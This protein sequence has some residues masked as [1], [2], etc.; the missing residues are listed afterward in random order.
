MSKK[1]L[2][3][4][5]AYFHDSAVALI[6]NGQVVAAA[7]EERFSRKKN[8]ASFP[9]HAIT[10]CLDFAKIDLTALEAVV[11]FEKPIVKFSRVVDS[12]FYSAPS[13]FL[14]Y[15]KTVPSWIKNKL[16]LRKT[17]TQE[18]SKLTLN[19][20]NPLPK[21]LFS[22]HHMSHAAASFYPSPFKSAAI[23][24]LD[25]VGEYS[26]TTAWLGEDTEIT[27]L[28]EIDFPDSLGL[29]YSAF[30]HYAGFKV[31]S[32]EYKL[33][34]LAP[35]GNP[36][37]VNQIMD[38]LI[39]IREDGSFK[40]NMVYFDFV[41]GENMINDRFSK[42]FGESAREPE[43]TVTQHHMDVAAS[44]QVVTEKVMM[45]LLNSLY[46]ETG[47]KKNLCLGGGVALNCVANGKILEQTKFEH[48]WIQPAA[49]DAGSALGG[50]LA[51][52]HQHYKEPRNINAH[53]DLM[54]ASYLGPAYD[55]PSIQK[56]LTEHEAHFEYLE[57]SE[58][59]K[60]V[61]KL[62]AE[63]HVVG[64]FQGRM[65]FGPRALGNRSILG[66]P[67]SEEMQKTMNL[68]IKFRESFR[69]FAP[70]VL[71]P[72][73]DKFFNF[74]GDSPY[75]LLVAQLHDAIKNP[76]DGSKDGL[77]KLY[78]KR[79][80]IPAVTHVDYSARI[81]TVHEDTNPKFFKLIQAFSDLTSVPILINTSFNVRGEPIVCSPSDALRCFMRTDMDY[82]VL[83]NYIL[84]KTQQKNIKNI[85]Y[86]IHLELD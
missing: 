77:D 70:A 86:S 12:Y 37:F 18:L 52:W 32:G 31:N 25:G 26:T 79:S 11:F 29:L 40:L 72:E 66:N 59:L 46:E 44:I 22:S 38:N 6:E 58:L 27:P 42:L 76:V 1:F 23:L 61:A 28:W 67:M 9:A 71:A 68:K 56:V 85:E 16:D 49:G 10:Y 41:A 65:E 34:G 55:L 75:M 14:N 53:K 78:Q 45:R 57:E 83:E 5:S 17:L 33:M 51:V 74:K 13:G 24:C 82:L 7:Q 8:D 69:P 80:L 30:T 73:V 47:G 36:I 84:D 50:A 15:M 64:W 4:I 2:L 21:I 81:Q 54:N 62:L 43:G 39:D 19:R 3:G 35:Y 20:F 48:L 63:N 60:K